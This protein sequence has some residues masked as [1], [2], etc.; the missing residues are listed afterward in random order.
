M[1]D[2]QVEGT[3]QTRA[4]TLFGELPRGRKLIKPVAVEIDYDDGEVVVSEPRFHM[5]AAAP[6][7]QEAKE[8]FKRVF[9]GY[10]DF[11]T[12]REQSLGGH[13]REQLEYLRSVIRQ[14]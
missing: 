12:E 5:H 14:A 2:R 6:T 10:L 7:E 3:V 13:L 4:D 11:L 1:A 8:A 9:S